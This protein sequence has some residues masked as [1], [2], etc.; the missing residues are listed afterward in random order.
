MG[1]AARVYFN[2][3]TGIREAA[4]LAE[5]G[6]RASVKSTGSEEGWTVIK[7]VTELEALAGVFLIT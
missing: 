3:A 5:A 4:R 1:K 7:S 6:G 2:Q